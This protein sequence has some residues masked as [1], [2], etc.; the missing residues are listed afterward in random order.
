MSSDTSGALLS[1]R[2]RDNSRVQPLRP[3]TI[4][5]VSNENTRKTV[6]IVGEHSLAREC[7]VAA[8]RSKKPDDAIEGFSN[9][10]ELLKRAAGPM[11]PSLILLCIRDARQS[12][13]ALEVELPAVTNQFRSVP[14]VLIVDNIDSSVI[15]QGLELG[16]RGVIPS[17]VPLA[18]ATLAMEVVQAGGTYL[19]IETY[20]ALRQSESSVKDT[21]ERMVTGLT[22]RQQAVLQALRRG[23]ANKV[24]AIELGMRESTVKVHVRNIMK[25][26]NARN[27]T[28]LSYKTS[29]LFADSGIEFKELCVQ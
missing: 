13:E 17:T 5:P 28:E 26:L 21:S 3:V 11:N 4:A 6:C 10:G 9:L 19:P 18:V 24:I 15:R 20:L 1:P 14:V 16:A 7:L 12:G 25:K 2:V 8:L 27:R 22:P 29:R 23:K